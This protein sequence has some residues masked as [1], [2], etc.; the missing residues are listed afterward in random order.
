M[1]VF[2]GCISIQ[3]RHQDTIEPSVLDG[4]WVKTKCTCDGKD[5]VSSD[6]QLAHTL[7]INGNFMVQNQTIRWKKTEWN[8]YCSVQESATIDRAADNVFEVTT[9]AFQSYYPRSATCKIPLAKAKRTWKILEVNKS[10]LKYES[11]NRC[12]KGPLSCTF[13]RLDQ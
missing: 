3:P 5:D 6:L 8:G 1:F 7:F 2:Q 4:G 10:E 13:R 11:T 12:E 9:V